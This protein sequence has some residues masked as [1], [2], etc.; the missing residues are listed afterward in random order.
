MF[1]RPSMTEIPEKPD[2]SKRRSRSRGN[3]EIGG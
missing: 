2:K 3:A 1:F